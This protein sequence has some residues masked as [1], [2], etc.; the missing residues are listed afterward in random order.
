MIASRLAIS[1]KIWPGGQVEHASLLHRLGH[2]RGDGCK[3]S[4]FSADRETCR[5]EV[6][7]EHGKTL[8]IQLLAEG[9]LNDKAEREVFFDLNGQ[10]RSI[11]VQDKEASKVSTPLLRIRVCLCLRWDLHV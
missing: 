1:T 10:M 4:S 7:I 11:F 6:E 2:R 9:K 5:I 8:A 3:S